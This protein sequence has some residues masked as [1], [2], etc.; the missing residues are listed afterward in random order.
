MSI[1]IAGMA[2]DE[3]ISRFMWQGHLH[4]VKVDADGEAGGYRRESSP[5]SVP[6]RIEC[7]H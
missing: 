7:K 4:R 3:M 6:S 2:S 5:H 1:C